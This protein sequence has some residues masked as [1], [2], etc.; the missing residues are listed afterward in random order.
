MP[1]SR[2]S[3]TF[4]D[5]QTNGRYG[6]IRVSKGEGMGVQTQSLL[7]DSKEGMW[8]IQV[9]VFLPALEAMGKDRQDKAIGCAYR[10]P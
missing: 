5:P 2:A 6:V 9:R 1:L 4:L 8:K 3:G 7:D 10:D